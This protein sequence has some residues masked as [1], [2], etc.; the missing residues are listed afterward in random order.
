[1]SRELEIVQHFCVEGT[2]RSA[3]PMGNGHINTTYL[4]ITQTE[5]KKEKQYTLQAINKYVFKDPEAVMKNIVAVTEHIEK[6]LAEYGKNVDRGVL[7]V[8]PAKDGRYFYLDSD[9]EYWRVYSYIDKSHTMDFVQDPD[10]LYAAGVGFGNFQ[11]MMADF[12]MSQLTETIPDFHNTP[13][14]Y[15]QL[16][17]A[18][19]EDPCGR[20]ALVKEEIDF[21]KNRESELGILTN[22]QQRGELPLRVVHNDTKFN[23]IL[24]DDETN[25]ALCII[26][27]DTVMPGLAASDFGDAIR[28]AASTAEED[29]TDLSKVS[30]NMELY[31]S[32]AKGFLSALDGK[33]TRA[34]IETLHWGVKII[35]MEIGMRFLTDYINGDKYFKIHREHHN[36]DRAR[37]QLALAKSMEENF[38]EMYRI[39]MDF[40][41]P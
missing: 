36:L 15:Q 25:E 20:V 23:N 1:M 27:L 40:V 13:S 7:R 16:L 9:G 39:I 37:C 6:K 41:K 29:E 3:R 11:N 28:F 18:I 26:D 17:D 5:D 38:D 4:V 30:V 14:R 8:V 12:P 10:Q 32:F 21:L 33:L 34:E 35:T 19:S 31:K 2:P 22:A 24:F